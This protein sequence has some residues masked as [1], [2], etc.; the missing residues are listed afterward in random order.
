MACTGHGSSALTKPRPPKPAQPAKDPLLAA[1]G[2][3]AKL[4][5]ARK[6][7]PR[8]ELAAAADISER[9][10][11]NL[12]SGIGNLSVL[13]LHQVALALDCSLAELLGDETTN[14]PEW[15]MIRAALH[16][17]G[18]EDLKQAH[19][20]IAD[21]FGTAPLAR[22]ED[23]IA[24]I[25][26][27]G[28]GKTTLGTMAAAALN[29]PFIELG[30]EISRL[31]GCSPHEIHGL[32]GPNGYRRYEH[33]ALEETLATHRACVIETAGGLVSDAATYDL[34]LRHCYTIWL[35]AAPEDHMKRVIAQGDLRPMS[36]SREAMDDLR[37]ILK[38]RT[39]FYAKADLIYDTSGKTLEDSFSGLMNRL[40]ASQ[41]RTGFTIT[42]PGS[43]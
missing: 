36:D 34:L 17:R 5:R 20:A 9:H 7:I 14:S 33:R 26:L 25:G 39:A 28:A 30:L 40:Y 43:A 18:T 22:R 12:E 3:R 27:R 21:T 13:M 42:A 29:L 2:E 10:L 19:R 24:L 31:A 38:G 41:G 8:R 11:A 15:L 4:L 32:Y 23:R 16:G 35:Q 6:G 1:L 37:L